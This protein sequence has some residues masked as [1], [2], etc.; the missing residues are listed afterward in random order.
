MSDDTLFHVEPV[1]LPEPAEKLSTERRRAL[2][3][4][5]ALR[6]G[7]HPLGMLPKILPG[8]LSL[9]PDAPP[10]D[11][12]DATG[13]RCG[14]CRFRRTLGYHNRTYGKCVH[15]GS[16][17]ADEI[18]VAGPPR[19]THGAATDVRAW[20]PGCR[21]WEPGDQALPDAMRWVPDPKE[22]R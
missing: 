19:V 1:P 5:T 9:H 10:A 12:R 18:E 21:D 2:R 20:W 8:H 13:P 4:L 11:D 16:R 7:T 6:A 17:G 14:N 15:P 22:M 3:Q